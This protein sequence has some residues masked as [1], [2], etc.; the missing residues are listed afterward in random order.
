MKPSAH[1]KFIPVFAAAIILSFTTIPAQAS[2]DIF[3]YIRSLFSKTDTRA[4]QIEKIVKD[5]SKP[6]SYCDE[7]FSKD[8]AKR[9]QEISAVVNQIQNNRILDWAN[10]N[11]K[12]AFVYKIL[13]KYPKYSK[14]VIAELKK[15]PLMKKSES[16][17]FSKDSF[18]TYSYEKE[19]KD[20]KISFFYKLAKYSDEE[21]LN[22]KDTE[23]L[24][25]LFH[26]SEKEIPIVGTQFKPKSLGEFTMELDEIRARESAGKVKAYEVKHHE[27]EL[28]LENHLKAVAE[29]GNELDYSNLHTHIVFEIEKN[30]SKSS[31]AAFFNWAKQK[32]DFI[33]FKG[34]EEGL[35]PNWLTGAA[36]K[37]LKKEINPL[38][39]A[40]DLRDKEFGLRTLPQS[41][42]EIG[43]TNHK[44]MAF[45]LRADIYGDA[46]S[47]YRRKIGIEIRDV[48][49]KKDV[50][51]N[52]V[53]HVS[54]SVTSERWI[55]TPEKLA[56]SFTFNETLIFGMNELIQV[57]VSKPFAKKLWES[58]T[59]VA[60]PLNSFENGKY[61]DYLTGKWISPT[62]EQ[63]AKIIKAR[64][65]YIKA[66][67]DLETEYH[68]LIQK[69]EKVP[70]DQIDLV[71][72]MCLGEWAS[73]AKIS[74][75]YA[76]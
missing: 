39:S 66:M 17:T 67:V 7:I 68:S 52:F 33:L 58:N 73:E 11:E 36:T 53:K 35:H 45:A 48:S 42:S 54:E 57:N 15:S 44:F 70:Q 56:E 27:F 5:C 13:P 62:P 60:L 24:E 19:G 30:Y 43:E 26:A 64:E 25:H 9:F 4:P 21:W 47:P 40:K 12:I 69:G 51:E 41:F 75:F 22:L 1:F 61:I 31:N 65:K 74:D 20:P 55:N 38:M 50:Y 29:T 76:R 2:C 6:F 37:R 16:P 71:I 46:I 63:S 72:K 8:P 34:M 10:T 23:R 28:S 32:N 18:L 14:N 3:G 49:R 59:F